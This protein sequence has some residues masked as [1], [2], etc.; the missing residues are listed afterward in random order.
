MEEMLYKFI[1]EGRREQEEIGEFI[2]EFKTTNKLLLKERNN[3]L[4]ELKF[5]TTTEIIRDTNNINK[6]PQILHHDKPV[7]PNEVLSETK[8]QETK[9]QTIYPPTPLIPFLHMLKK[10]REEAQQRKFLENLKKLHINI[11][12]TEALSQMPKLR[13]S[14]SLMPYMMYEKLGLGEPKPTRMSLELADR[15]I[16]YPRGIA[17]NVL[18]KNDKFILP[19][20]FVNLDMREDSETPIILKRSFLATARAMIDVFNKTITLMVGNED[21][22]F[23]VDQTIK[24]PPAEEDECYGIDFLDITIHLKT[25]EL[26]KDDQLDSFLVNN[27]EESI[28]I[29]D[30]ESCDESKTHIRR[31]EEVNTPYSQETK[32]EHLYSTSANKIKKIVLKDLP[33]HLEYTQDGRGLKRQQRV[34]TVSRS[35]RMV[36]FFQIPIAPEDQEKTTFTCP[37]G[38]FAYRRMP[39]G[40]CNAPATFQRCMKAIFHDMVEDFVEVFMNDFLVLGRNIYEEGFYWPSIFKD[41]KDYVMKCDA[42]QKSG[43]ISSRN[44]MPQNNI[45]CN[46]DLTAAAKNRLMEL[47][48]LMELRDGAYENTRI[49]KERTKRWHDSRL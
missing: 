43:N 44:K 7:E 11:P 23:Y 47:N 18:I 33:S 26:L 37:Y 28:D 45:Q 24:R 6:E 41:A 15:S 14:I 35:Y 25:Q 38:T 30:L 12:F 31:I 34:N 48:E 42:C 5:E 22:I 40:L 4:S 8:P 13:T 20:D 17:E 19:V 2:R 27:L 3:S 32:N 46:M 1:D 39:F 49:Y 21:V 9:E 36:G 29:S 10:E 16:Q